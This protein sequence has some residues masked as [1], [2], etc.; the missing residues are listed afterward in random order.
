MLVV[1]FIIT[2]VIDIHG[3]R[4]EIF[5]LVSEIHEYVDSVLGIKEY[6]SVRRYYKFTRVML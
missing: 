5:T 3:H 2:L 6:I 1:L 4:F